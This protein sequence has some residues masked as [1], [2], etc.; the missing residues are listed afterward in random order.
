[1]TLP[2]HLALISYRLGRKLNWNSRKEKFV[3]DK[4]ANGM[5][6]REYRKKWDLL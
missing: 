4:E 5:L 3:D 1:M 2:M 6:H